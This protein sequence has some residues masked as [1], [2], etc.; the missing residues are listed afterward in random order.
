MFVDLVLYLFV[1]IVKLFINT[2]GIFLF[3]VLCINNNTGA[4]FLLISGQRH[5]N[6]SFPLLSSLV[7]PILAVFSLLHIVLAFHFAF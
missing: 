7:Y 3:L 4:M 5:G 2:L 1:F 6:L